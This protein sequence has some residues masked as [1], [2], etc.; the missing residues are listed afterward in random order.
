MG[1]PGRPRLYLNA[2][3]ARSPWVGMTEVQKSGAIIVWPATDSGA[4]PPAAVMQSFP[5]IVPEVPRA[6]ERSIQGRLPLLRIGWTM[7]RPQTEDRGQTAQ[8]GKT[9]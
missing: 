2:T 7:I 3:P 6:F 1:A 8:D 5:G 4:T 9:Q